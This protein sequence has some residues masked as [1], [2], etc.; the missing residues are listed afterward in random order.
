MA[1]AIDWPGSVE[2]THGNSSVEGTSQRGKG[3]A[4]LYL[5]LGALS[6]RLPDITPPPASAQQG[7]WF[8]DLA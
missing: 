7:G 1:V 6:R 2:K 4:P 5:L 8:C 3:L